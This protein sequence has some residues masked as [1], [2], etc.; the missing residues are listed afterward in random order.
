MRFTTRSLQILASVVAAIAALC[1]AAVRQWDRLNQS[2]RDTYRIVHL[3]DL[4]LK[5]EEQ[6]GRWPRNWEQL[7]QSA[8]REKL[9]P[10]VFAD[11]KANITVDFSFDPASIDTS[12]P[13]SDSNPQVQIFVSSRGINYGA[14]FDPNEE[15][16]LRL[17]S[18]RREK[19]CEDSD[20]H[21]EAEPSD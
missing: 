9:C 17:Q 10:A 8:E 12:A 1:M 19:K 6:T 15:V 5:Y 13:W 4:F 20:A 7:E 3:G 2:I 14:T 11:A 18:K 16:Y 21:S